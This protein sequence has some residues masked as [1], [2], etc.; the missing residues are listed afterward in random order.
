MCVGKLSKSQLQR[1]SS[2]LTPWRSREYHWLILNKDFLRPVRLVGTRRVIPFKAINKINRTSSDTGVSHSFPV[3]HVLFIL[4]GTKIRIN[5]QIKSNMCRGITTVAEV[6]VTVEEKKRLQGNNQT[7]CNP[8]SSP[9]LGNETKR[10]EYKNK[11]ETLRDLI[12]N[13]WCQRVIRPGRFSIRSSR[14]I[15]I[16]VE[17]ERRTCRR[18]TSRW[19]LWRFLWSRNVTR[20]CRT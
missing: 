1:I 9:R 12:P 15:A 11:R 2:E 8:N 16:Q 17:R 4:R 6:H 7:I 5:A 18:S 3:N 20:K 19:I 10:R 13:H 14:R